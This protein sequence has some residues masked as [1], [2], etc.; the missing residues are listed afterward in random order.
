MENTVTQK[1]SKIFDDFNEY[2]ESL[3]GYRFFR[4][5]YCVID[6][7]VR[8]FNICRE[9]NDFSLIEKTIQEINQDYLLSSEYKMRKNFRSGL[10]CGYD[11][12]HYEEHR[13]ACPFI[14]WENDKTKISYLANLLNNNEL[15]SYLNQLRGYDINVL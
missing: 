15:N 4:C 14:F 10:V 11:C 5:Y 6:I 8:A 2:F 9:N 13:E 7:V 1:I 12:P 3:Y